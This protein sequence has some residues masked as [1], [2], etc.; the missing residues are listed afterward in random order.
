MTGTLP[1][2]KRIQVLRGIA[3]LAVILIHTC[4][5]GLWQVYCRPFVNF[6][7]G[8][9]LFLSGFLTSWDQEDWGA[10][11]KRRLLRVL[12]PYVIWTILYTLVK[13][14]P[15]RLAFH[16]LTTQG[17]FHLYF[18]FVYVQLVLLTPLVKR[19]AASRFRWTGWLITPLSILVFSYP[20]LVL[21]AP[22]PGRISL[23]WF[24]SCLGWFSYYYMGLLLRQTD[25]SVPSRFFRRPY[26]W[27]TVALVLQILEGR[28]WF[29]LGYPDPGTPFKLTSL[30]CNLLIMAVAFRFIRDGETEHSSFW[31]RLGDCSFGIY[32]S[33]VLFLWF[34]SRIPV[35]QDIPFPANAALVLGASFATVFLCRRFGNKTVN[36]CLGFI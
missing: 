33:H 35:L 10:F 21:P 1:K 14:Q 25:F 24:L 17:A 26:L 13:R 9:F 31:T 3:I 15:E 27:I 4:P 28:I 22:L 32:L 5:G 8:L 16:L 20:G 12:V 18:I 36:R 34:F 23:I 2:N 11:F 29:A 6:A 19:L 30:L 7:V